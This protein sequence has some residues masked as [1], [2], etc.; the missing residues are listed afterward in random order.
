MIAAAPPFEEFGMSLV[1]RICKRLAELLVSPWAPDI[2]GRAVSRCFDEH[3]FF[4]PNGRE[5]AFD[6][7]AV[8]PAIAKVVKIFERFCAG[9]L[10]GR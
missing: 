8:F 9:V 1:R 7:D 4:F 5:N 10:N 2:L 6:F 3:R